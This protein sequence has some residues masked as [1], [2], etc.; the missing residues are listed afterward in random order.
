MKLPQG[1]MVSSLNCGVYPNWGGGLLLKLTFRNRPPRVLAFQSELVFYL[2]E[3]LKRSIVEGKFSDPRGIDKHS[4]YE[5]V[6][7]LRP[8]LMPVD[9]QSANASSTVSRWKWHV[10]RD[11]DSVAVEFQLLEGDYETYVFTS[12]VLFLFLDY[13]DR[14][15]ENG[16]LVDLRE[17][18]HLTAHEMEEEILD[19]E[20]YRLKQAYEH[21]YRSKCLLDRNYEELVQH[22]QQFQGRITNPDFVLWVCRHSVSIFME[23]TLRL[24][25][26]FVAACSSL[27]DHSRV[28]IRKLE[29]DSKPIPG[30]KEEIDRRFT[31]DPLSQFVVNLRQFAQ[32]YRLP[33][34]STEKN[35]GNDGIK[36]RV[37]LLKE[38]LLLF[39]NWNAHAKKFIQDQNDDI[40][41]LE[42]LS[43]YHQNIIVFH[44]WL[45]QEWNHTFQSE[46]HETELKRQAFLFKKGGSLVSDL[47]KSLTDTS[48]ERGSQLLDLLSPFLSSEELHELHEFEAASP[49]LVRRAVAFAEK[50]YLLPDDLKEALLTFRSL[51]ENK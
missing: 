8:T 27:I 5:K 28:F 14:S 36:G 12:E 31:N 16:H 22:L 46:L 41:I 23:E 2:Q 7:E 20:G 18:R 48:P 32:H 3:N 25:H 30:Y 43:T 4:K 1:S 42:V 40:N 38:D 33:S 19:S 26:N 34:I 21:F 39:P 6:V 37:L 13:V 15:I 11:G 35:F 51:E 24:L 17:F 49:E 29:K 9:F 50:R 47:R 44:T 45:Q 10:F